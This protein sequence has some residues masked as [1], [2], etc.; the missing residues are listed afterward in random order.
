MGGLVVELHL[1]HGVE[2]SGVALL[3]L[4]ELAALERPS[5]RVLDRA[6]ASSCAALNTLVEARHRAAFVIYTST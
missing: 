6:R 5:D 4:G 3:G 2:R 1:E